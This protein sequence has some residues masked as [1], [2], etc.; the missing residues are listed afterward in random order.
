VEDLY[1]AVNKDE[2]GDELLEVIQNLNFH[3]NPPLRDL[4]PPPSLNRMSKSVR[5]KKLIE[6]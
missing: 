3:V 4:L 5:I 2:A 6:F 1:K